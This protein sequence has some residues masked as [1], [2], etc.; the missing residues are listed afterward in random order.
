MGGYSTVP[1]TGGNYYIGLPATIYTLGLLPD[2]AGYT[3]EDAVDPTIA[4]LLDGGSPRIRAAHAGNAKLVSCQWT[5]GTADNDAIWAFYRTGTALGGNP[6]YIALYGVDGSELTTYLA[7]FVPRTFKLMKQEG[8][9]YVIGC[10]MYVLPNI[11]NPSA[12]LALF[13]GWS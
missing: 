8:N 7:W 5:L 12:D 11:I 2:S 9:T 10:Q 3:V 6:F 4:Q 13:E 1:G